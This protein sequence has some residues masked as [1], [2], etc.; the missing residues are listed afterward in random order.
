MAYI[1]TVGQKGYRAVDC[2]PYATLEEAEADALDRN[3]RAQELGL[4]VRYGT[5]EIH[6]AAPRAHH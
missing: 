3:L 2:G 6:G 4:K 5:K 1:V